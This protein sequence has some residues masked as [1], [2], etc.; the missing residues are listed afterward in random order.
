V[1]GDEMPAVKR[2]EFAAV[3]HT[4][5]H[6]RPLPVLIGAMRVITGFMK[7][8]EVSV[9]TT[10]LIDKIGIKVTKKLEGLM[11]RSPFRVFEV[12]SETH[13]SLA[14]Y[15]VQA[16]KHL[17]ALTKYGRWPKRSLWFLFVH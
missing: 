10:C 15:L 16:Q 6:K 13:Q 11:T 17:R 12:A 7:L 14:S 8:F 4:A 3:S 9:Y 5:E 1:L 2:V